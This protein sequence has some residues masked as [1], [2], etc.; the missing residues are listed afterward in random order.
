MSTKIYLKYKKNLLFTFIY[1]L[2]ILV[3][4]E[5]VSRSFLFLV[6]KNNKIYF[7]GI[8]KDIKIIS[9]SFSNFEFY[10]S[11]QDI[12][13]KKNILLKS[14]KNNLLAWV[15]GGSQSKGEAC[16]KNSSSWP[17]ILDKRTNY[18]LINY[19]KHNVNTDF[20]TDLLISELEK[21]DKIPNTIF[22]SHKLNER[23]VIS[24]GLKRNNKKIKYDFPNQKIN[25]INYYLKSVNEGIKKKIV[26]YYFIDETILRIKQKIGINT[27]KI[28]SSKQSQ[29]EYEIA[30]KNYKLN[31]I[32]AINISKKYGIKNFYLVSL[33]DNHN[34]DNYFFLKFD[35]T[36]KSLA[37]NHNV[38][39]IDTAKYLKKYNSENLFCDIM[40]KTKNG[41]KIT[42]QIIQ[43]FIKFNKNN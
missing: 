7:Y 31:T 18:K 36:I 6:T 34:S 43:K 13:N 29:K 27:K 14:N 39:Y 19:A 15:F 42:A 26:F 30:I 40:H 28:K 37:A 5:I 21:K 35:K 32:D 4:I 11:D 25:K 10:I 24:F 2:I 20:S 23:S 33:F 16:G 17:K 8:N 38:F 22:W 1:L 12:L 9:H 3:A 41:N